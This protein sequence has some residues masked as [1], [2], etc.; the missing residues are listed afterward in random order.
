MKSRVSMS[1]ANLIT[2]T[3]AGY[4]CMLHRLAFILKQCNRA[5]MKLILILL[6]RRIKILLFFSYLS[7]S[8][9]LTFDDPRN[10][11]LSD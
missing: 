11:F 10:H 8:H 1:F 9:A 4:L 6:Q 2:Y 7:Y 3:S 5:I